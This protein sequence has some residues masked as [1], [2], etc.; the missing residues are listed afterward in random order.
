MGILEG[1]SLGRSVFALDQ[2][3]EHIKGRER[4]Q[5][6]SSVVITPD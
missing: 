1:I 3:I 2:Q 5:S 6:L 4:V